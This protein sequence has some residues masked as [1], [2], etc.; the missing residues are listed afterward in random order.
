MEKPRSKAVRSRSRSIYRKRYSIWIE[1][2][3]STTSTTGR[4]SVTMKM[5]LR[6]GRVEYM[7]VV[8]S[9]NAQRLAAQ[10]ADRRTL[11]ARRVLVAG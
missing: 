9:V 8:A 6:W 10:Q 2:L 3:A 4:L 5:A 11:V 7:V 1:L